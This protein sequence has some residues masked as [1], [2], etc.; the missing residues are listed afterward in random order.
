MSFSGEGSGTEL[1]PYQITSWAQL[2]EIANDLDKW[3][4]LM[5][6]LDSDSPGYDDYASES[7]NGGD[8]WTA[9][10]NWDEGE[11]FIGVFDGNNKTISDLFI[12]N[13][14]YYQGLFSAVVSGA[15]KDIGLV[16]VNITCDAI[17][18]GLIGKKT[19]SVVGN[20]YWDTET[21]EQGESDGG[22]GLSTAE[23]KSINSY[24]DW[25][26]SKV[27]KDYNN[28]YPYLR[29]Q[30]KRNVINVVTTPP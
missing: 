23:I 8:G 17:V 7:A 28:G 19:A 20:S 5:N 10:G 21:S 16:D 1:D 4:I 25:D 6:D 26:I 3:F 18:G 27:I 13:T 15:V 9:I 22:A 30:I 29:W 2:A 11:Y 12:D 14:S 24:S